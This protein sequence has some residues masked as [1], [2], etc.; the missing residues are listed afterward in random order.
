MTDG[1]ASPLTIKI[2]TSITAIG[3]GD[4]NR[5]AFGSDEVNP[6]LRFEF[7]HALE[8][9]GSVGGRTGWAPLHI[10][11]EQDG[12]IAG[13]MATYAKTHSQ[14]EYVFDY[15]WADAFERAGGRYYPKLQ[16]SVPFTPVTGPRLLIAASGDRYRVAHALIQGAKS[17]LGTINGSSIHATFVSEA[18]LPLFQAES[19]LERNDQQFHW[20]N[21]GYATYEDFLL[22]LASRKRKTIKR[23]RRD[24]VAADITIERL[25]GSS[26]TDEAWDAYFE[27]YMDTGSRK[28]GRPYLNRAFYRQIAETMADDVLLVM[29]RR[30]GRYI[31]GAINFIGSTALFG[32]NWGCSEHHPFLHFEVCYHQAIEF[33]IERGLA[34]VEAGAQ[35]EH[36]LARGYRPVT[37]RS[38]HWI[39]NPSFRRAVDDYLER[40]RQQVAMMQAALEEAAPFRKGAVSTP[41][42]RLEEDE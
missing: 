34:R 37:T 30:Q 1:Q 12:I 20:F 40:E 39:E 29:A 42:R 24:A 28:W 21:D 36:K 31:A 7:L 18:D 25:S 26:L 10:V 41:P 22:S 2:A 3:R 15:G 13:V 6:F 9:S 33:A 17:A 14:G 11:V 23:E 38:V 5:C 4:W 8:A 27:F 16:I 19:F 35:G 32:R